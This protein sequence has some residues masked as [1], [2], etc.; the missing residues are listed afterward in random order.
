MRGA[1]A[2]LGRAASLGRAPGR[3]SRPAC[4]AAAAP[5]PPPRLPPARRRLDD[6]ALD[7]APPGTSRNV[8]QAWIA[9]GLVYVDGEKATKAGAPIKPG[10][11]VD[12]RATED[13]YVCRAGHK[14]DAA[15]TAFAV[16]VS[17]VAA[18][19]C[20]L[21]TGGFADCLLQRGAAHVTGIDVGYGQVAERVRVDPRVVVVERTNARRVTR[22]GLVARGAPGVYGLATLDVSFI[23]VLKVGGGG[24]VGGGE[25]GNAAADPHAL[26]RPPKILPA[27]SA[28]LSPAADLVVLIK[29][30]FEAGRGQVGAGGVVR[31][32]AVR[33]EVVDAVVAGVQAAGF[34]LRG[35][36]I[37][38]PLR[39][40][41]KGN[42]EYLAHF[43]K[44]DRGGREGDAAM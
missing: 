8:V 12:V 22:A 2:R 14:L 20:G 29:P 9:R 37:E 30:Q 25:G 24:G 26:A 43:E 28:L 15:L 1:A 21:S 7:V 17:G 13:K 34:A 35:G 31:D 4:A 5:G 41:S 3:A 32:A 6:V 27:I 19:D 16:P 39:G 40:A 10:A 36:P 44:V 33:A 18:V 23:S 38:S 42:V 11:V